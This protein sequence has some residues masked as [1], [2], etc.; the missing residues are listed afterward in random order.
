MTG[1]RRGKIVQHSCANQNITNTCLSKSGKTSALLR[2]SHTQCWFHAHIEELLVAALSTAGLLACP[3]HMTHGEHVVSLYFVTVCDAPCASLE[4][5]GI[6][7]ITSTDQTLHTCT[8]DEEAHQQE[9]CM[10]QPQ[11]PVPSRYPG[12]MT[13][14]DIP[15]QFNHVVGAATILQLPT[16]NHVLAV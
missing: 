5:V 13:A 9:L 2:L 1:V 8:T 11:A 6:S 12:W 3:P 16:S 15:S 4:A 10:Q 14:L 7:V